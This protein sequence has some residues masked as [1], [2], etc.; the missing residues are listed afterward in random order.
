MDGWGAK[1]C[2]IGGLVGG[3]REIQQQGKGLLST[4]QN[5]RKTIVAFGFGQ[6][7]SVETRRWYLQALKAKKARFEFSGF[8]G[9]QGCCL[10]RWKAKTQP[11]S[12]LFRSPPRKASTSIRNLRARRVQNLNIMKEIRARLGRTR[13][14]LVSI[15]GSPNYRTHQ[16]ITKLAVTK[17]K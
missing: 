6:T 9:T 4:P 5:M 11:S 13:W 17:I 7:A 15:F 10:E 8:N 2:G 14:P 16:K 3:G 12:A 1:R